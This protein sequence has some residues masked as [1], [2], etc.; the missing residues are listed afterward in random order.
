M[1]R[2]IM[3]AL[4]CILVAL[5]TC[6][7]ALAAISATAPELNRIM[8]EIPDGLAYTTSY[9]PEKHLFKITIKTAET[10]WARFEEA[11]KGLNEGNTATARGHVYVSAPANATQKRMANHWGR[12]TDLQL[13]GEAQSYNASAGATKSYLQL[14]SYVVDD[15]NDRRSFL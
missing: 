12:M 10:D 2:K 6:A 5:M 15:K 1:T 13:Y 9:A 11:L 3:A 7:A 8:V 14:G 4:V